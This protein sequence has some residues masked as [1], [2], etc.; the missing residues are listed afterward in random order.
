ME[1]SINI[2]LYI[3]LVYPRIPVELALRFVKEI[4]KKNTGKDLGIRGAWE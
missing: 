2:D 1:V 4:D 3:S